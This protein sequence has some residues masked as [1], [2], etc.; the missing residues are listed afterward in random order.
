MDA[1]VIVD[2]QVG[3]LEGAPKH[4]LGGVIDRINALTAMVR[5][6]GGTVIWIRHCGKPGDSFERGGRGWA[7]LPELSRCQDDLLVEKS[8]NDPYVGTRLKEMLEGLAPHRVLI[9]GWATDFCV[10]AT[11]RSTVSCGHNVVV[12]QDG[13]TLADRPHLDAPAVI[14]HHNWIWSNLITDRSITVLPADV[15][16]AG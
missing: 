5:R 14:A 7:F 8:L 3:L 1:I 13:H 6:E 2:M 16:L 15:L 9:A 11:V 12:V 10:D 4:D